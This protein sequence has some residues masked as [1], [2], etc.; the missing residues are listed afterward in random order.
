M[1]FPP[2][3][4]FPKRSLNSWVNWRFHRVRQSW[5]FPSIGSFDHPEFTNLQL[6]TC[7]FPMSSECTFLRADRPLFARNSTVV[8]LNSAIPLA[9]GFQWR[10]R[11]SPRREIAPT[12][13][14]LLHFP[15]HLDKS[16][17][18]ESNAAEVS[19]LPFTFVQNHV[20]KR[21]ESKFRSMMG[22]SD[23]LSSDV[24]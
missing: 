12:F 24:A 21:L 15:Y 22:N 17:R 6:V 2:L 19:F 3:Y 7:I 4:P 23:N 18:T 11:I 1:D 8:L 13:Q 16:T 9:S 20:R 5:S 10:R 14:I